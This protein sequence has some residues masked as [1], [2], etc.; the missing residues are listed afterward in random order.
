MALA[1]EITFR[2]FSRF[3]LFVKPRKAVELKL[4]FTKGQETG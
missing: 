3:Q 2:F 1:L 4:I